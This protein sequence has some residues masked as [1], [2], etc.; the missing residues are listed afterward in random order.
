MTDAQFHTVEGLI[1]GRWGMLPANA[2]YDPS[3]LEP[4]D[5]P[6]WFLD[7]DM[8]VS[9]TQPFEPESLMNTS[10]RFAEGIYFVFR[11]MVT[12]EFLKFYGGQP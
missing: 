7:L 2:T 1:Q 11:Q 9:S 12:D 4:V 6:S 10:R 8:F 5:A 3:V